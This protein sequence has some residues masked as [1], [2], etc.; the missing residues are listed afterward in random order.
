M[1]GLSIILIALFLMFSFG[2]L[3]E[4][5]ND[6]SKQID[7]ADYPDQ[8][9]YIEL[10]LS[11]SVYDDFP[12]SEN[13]QKS[14]FSNIISSS[15]LPRLSISSLQSKLSN[16]TD[17]PN[18]KGVMIN[19]YS[20]FNISSSE[21]MELFDSLQKLKFAKPL[22]IYSDHF[23]TS[24]YM[25]AS[26][27]DKI[28]LPPTGTVNFVNF[29]FTQIGIDSFLS[30][31]GVGVEIFKKGKFKSTGLLNDIKTENQ[32]YVFDSLLQDFIKYTANIYLKIRPELNIDLIKSWLNKALIFED[33]ALDLNI[34]TDIN[35]AR[36]AKYL[37]A[38]EDSTKHI[39]NINE[40]INENNDHKNTTTTTNEDPQQP[41]WKSY[42]DFSWSGAFPS[43]NNYQDEN[44]K[45]KNNDLTDQSDQSSDQNKDSITAKD[46]SSHK[47]KKSWFQR[48]FFLSRQTDY[49]DH[50][51]NKIAYLKYTGDIVNSVSDSR[52]DKISLKSVKKDIKWIL[53]K[54][55]QIKAVVIEIDS[56]GGSATSSELIWSEL[57][58]IT[59]AGIKVVA[60]LDSIATSGGF[61]IATAADHII[62]KPN[63]ITGSIGVI[64]LIP[65]IADLLKKYGIQVKTYTQAEYYDLM[66]FAQKLLPNS[67]K[68]IAK[69]VED[70][71]NLFLTR[72]A[73]NRGIDLAKADELSQGMIW[74]GQQ[75]YDIK[76]IDSLGNNKDAVET[77][78]SLADLENYEII[79]PKTNISWKTCLKN[80]LLCLSST[81]EQKSHALLTHPS[82]YP[83]DLLI[84]LKN[85][86][87][88]DSN[89][90]VQTSIPNLFS[91]Y[92]SDFFQ[93][94]LLIGVKYLKDLSSFLN[95]F[96]LYY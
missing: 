70:S 8:P 82:F 1:I 17:H 75:A 72:V 18:V 21:A 69:T 52:L 33:D 65:D 86:L 81:G 59:E 83:S 15:S 26:H 19:L 14:D 20:D 29:A 84:N 31:I 25:V 39:E 4:I 30:K 46:Q 96:I 49:Q 40:N 60:Y 63:T 54:K 47:H 35:H 76:L 38:K 6:S 57:K 51:L 53:D 3:L 16:L 68:L 23:T 56:P 9:V 91:L 71:Y 62:A 85:P 55:D 74:T 34:I 41:S 37:I 50:K 2:S 90:S 95:Y 66:N 58:Y 42:S 64:A 78:A 43:N 80:P 13:N 12:Y 93:T 79:W 44:E 67:K 48:I 7:L 77:A 89:N 24:T 32:Q 45:T 94:Y 61:Y 73:E 92:Q 11:G 87:D 36:K 10:K 5:F 88:L 22:Y 28:I 27:G